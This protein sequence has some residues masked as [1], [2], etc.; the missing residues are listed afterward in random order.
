MWGELAHSL[1]HANGYVITIVVL[2]FLA[3]VVF[4]ERLFML[5]IV[6]H[7]D[8]SK[9]L[10][11]LRKLVAAEDVDRAIN[12]CKAVSSTS[13][14]KISLKALEAAET[15]PTRV[16]ATIEEETIEFLPRI[17]QRLGILP[18]FTMLI[19]LAGILGTIDALWSAFHSVDVLDTAKKQATLAQG[20]AS[21]LN[22]TAMGLLFGML[23]LAG[24]YLLKGLAVGLTDR[25]HHGVAVLNNL[26]VPQ[27][28]VA[29]APVAMGEATAAAPAAEAGTYAK[30]SG[31]GFAE[32]N[33]KG[34]GEGGDGAD[35]SFDDVSVEDIKDE[36]EII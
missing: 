6:Y 17:E 19:M 24:Y 34:K 36:E 30:A 27:D 7:I 1:Q 23:L 33:D 12:L 10:G 13:L 15:D 16:R 35:E 8:F 28:V 29:Y 32:E 14:P 11:N 31:E 9:F 2:G 20:I 18:A 25:I 26:L 21:A 3:T 4:F 22:P 5:Q